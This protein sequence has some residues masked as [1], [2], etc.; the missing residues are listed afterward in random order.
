MKLNHLK[1]SKDRTK[2]IIDNF[3]K[4]QVMIIGDLMVNK[5][6]SPGFHRIG[7]GPGWGRKRPK[8]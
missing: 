3:P 4:L 1:I 8:K 7:L 2:Q 6:W 5:Y